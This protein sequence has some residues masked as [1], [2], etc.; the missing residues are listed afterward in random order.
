MAWL[1]LSVSIQKVLSLT[2]DKIFVQSRKTLVF[3]KTLWYTVSCLH[4]QD[5][6]QYHHDPIVER[7]VFRKRVAVACRLCHTAP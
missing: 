4:Q 3:A 1:R 2:M 7:R 5:V 6:F